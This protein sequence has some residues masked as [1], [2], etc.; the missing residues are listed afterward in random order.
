MQEIYIAFDVETPNSANDRM[1][2]IGLT[3]IYNGKITDRFYTLIN[4]ETYF[5]PFNSELTGI[6][7]EDVASAPTFPE[8][9]AMIENAMSRGTLVAH[10]APFDMSV[11][12]KCLRDYGIK[13]KARVPYLCTCTLS[14]RTFR[15][16]SNHKLNTLC[17]CLDIRLEHHNAGSDADACANLLLCCAERGADVRSAIKE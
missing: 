6:Y 1:S 17:D 5:S 3:L 14:K 13:W 10:N 7:P 4:P 12:A 8:V 15:E 9:W 11:L 2:A 16:L